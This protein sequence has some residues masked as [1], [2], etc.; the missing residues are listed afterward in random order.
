MDIVF[1]IG[2]YTAL[3]MA[4]NSFGVALDDGLQ[5]FPR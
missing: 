1:T 3:A 4:L 5:G 2:N